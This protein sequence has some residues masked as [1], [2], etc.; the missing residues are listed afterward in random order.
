[1]ESAARVTVEEEETPPIAAVNGSATAVKEPFKMF[2]S[3]AK[4]PRVD[5]LFSDV[6]LVIPADLC[7]GCFRRRPRWGRC[8]GLQ[9]KAIVD[10]VS[11]EFRAGEL[12][13]IMGPSGAGKSSLMN[14][15]AGYR[16]R[17]H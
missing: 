7:A 3:V 6:S 11:G 9:E 12:T 15:M 16:V 5:I 13:A 4:R 10:V 14:I 2:S 1:M 8:F 17:C